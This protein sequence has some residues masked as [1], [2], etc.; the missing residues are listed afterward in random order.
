MVKALPP[1]VFEPLP[2]LVQG[3]STSLIEGGDVGPQFRSFPWW[4]I[5]VEE[6]L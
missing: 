5:F 1:E 6:S 4:E 2:S 3:F